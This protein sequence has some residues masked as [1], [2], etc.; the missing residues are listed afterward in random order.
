M[1]QKV[2]LQAK[3]KGRDLDSI[4]E[5]IHIDSPDF[6]AFMFLNVMHDDTDNNELRMALE[7]L[8]ENK[9]NNISLT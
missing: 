1:V 6:D 4:V 8:Q 7:S 2:N 5:K 3:L 9:K